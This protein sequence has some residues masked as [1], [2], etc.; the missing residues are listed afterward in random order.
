M[1]QKVKSLSNL[2]SDIQ[3]LISVLKCSS[4]ITTPMV[5]EVSDPNGL[6]RH[7]LKVLVCLSGEGTLTGQEI[8]QLM[9]MPPMNVSRALSNL[10]D[11]G[12]LEPVDDESNR[13]RRPYRI[14]AKG[15]RH[16]NAML[17]EF[18][19]VGARLFAS[20]NKKDRIELQRLLDLMNDQLESWSELPKAEAKKG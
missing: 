3:L 7:E 4:L 1:T 11:K 9:S 6:T 18:R 16:Y 20:L 8:S 19:S 14:S 15:W 10:Y 13:R 5:E 17:P 2:G 12:W